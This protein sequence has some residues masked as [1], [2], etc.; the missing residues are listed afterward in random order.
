VAVAIVLVLAI[1]GG[2]LYYRVLN[3]DER[4]RV[5]RTIAQIVHEL[6]EF[7]RTKLAPFERA[8]RARTASAVVTPALVAVNV[9]IF[10]CMLL[11]AGARSDPSTV[12]SWGA[13]FGPRTTNGEWW[14]LVTAPFVNPHLI[15][16]AVDMATIV[17]VGFTLERLVGAPAFAAAYFVGG[18]FSGLQSLSSMPT[19]VMAGSA[20][21]VF[22][23]YGLLVA[24]VGL[25]WWRPSDVTI[26]RVALQRL[27]PITAIFVLCNV[28][29]QGLAIGMVG[30]VTGMLFG[31][32]VA[33]DIADRTP[34]ARRMAGAVAIGFAIASIAAF[35]M[36]GITDIR[37][38]LQRLIDMEHRTADMYQAASANSARGKIAAADLSDLIERSI[39]PELKAA[40][41]RINALKGVPRQNQQELADARQYLKLR[42][43]SW[44]LRAKGLRDAGTRVG[45]S[46]AAPGSKM[47][48][49]A[50]AV[51]RHQSTMRTLGRAEGAE[52]E[53]LDVLERLRQ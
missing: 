24:C 45:P 14:R 16:L 1:I 47:T 7:G 35:S 19:D 27:A 28:A 4:L 11:G 5:I 17:Q 31:L 46:G 6:K 44:H 8:L 37:P 10:V 32:A 42:S 51:A 15:L 33:R 43:E 25:T 39:I 30:L 50:W 13:S 38:E 2:V 41:A 29:Y 26:P 49:R 20:G 12:V 3:S 52:R 34:P 53:S 23:L 18:V 21:A 48:P 36:R 40:D 9:L 22:G